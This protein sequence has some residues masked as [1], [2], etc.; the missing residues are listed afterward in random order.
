MTLRCG[1]EIRKSLYDHHSTACV[2]DA[3][4]TY[5]NAFKSHVSAGFERWADLADSNGLLIGGGEG[6]RLVKLR[7]GVATDAD[8]LTALIEAAYENM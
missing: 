6:M 8:A 1:A 3:A 4:F 5:V 7:L 2:G